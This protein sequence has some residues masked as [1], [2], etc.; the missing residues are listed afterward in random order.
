MTKIDWP[1]GFDRTP[2]TDREP[3]RSFEATIAQ[4]SSA[5]AKE[6]DRMGVNEW[7][8]S[9]ASGG[10][11]TKSNGLPKHSANPDDPAA[12]VYWQKDGEQ[13]A[14]ACDDSPRLRDNM[15]YCYKWINETRMRSNRPV[16]TG[17]SEFATARLPSGNEDAV[18]ADPPA[19]VVLGVDRDASP[20]EVEA[21]FRE[22]AREVHPDAGGSDEAFKRAQ[23]AKEE[24]LPDENECVTDGGTTEYHVVDE[25]DTLEILKRIPNNPGTMPFRH[26][27]TGD[28]PSDHLGIDDCIEA[29]LWSDHGVALCTVDDDVADRT[30]YVNHHGDLQAVSDERAVDSPHEA[31][32]MLDSE[33][34]AEGFDVVAV[35]AEDAPEPARS[36]GKEIVT[37]G[38]ERVSDPGA[39][40][41][42]SSCKCWRSHDDGDCTI[43]GETIAETEA[44][45][46]RVGHCKHDATD[47]YAGRGRG[48]RDML[49]VPKPGKR[50]WLGNPFTL[51]DHSRAES[52]RAFRQAFE[53][54]LQRDDEFRA[55]VADL[56]GKTLGCWCQ[57]VSD[58]EPGCHAEVIAEWA[59]RLANEGDTALDDA[60]QIV[61]D[62]GRP[63]LRRCS[64]CGLIHRPTEACRA[65]NGGG[66]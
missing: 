35:L 65:A 50:G 25:D 28:L 41:Y 21:A 39:R 55:A 26:W 11:H 19:H 61:T 40:V 4:T 10:S 53:D 51:D 38:G 13:F 23:R 17:E 63:S 2:A 18:A 9:T 47:V 62:G 33:L 49:S 15:R 44:E 58:S 27:V 5:L 22:T 7:R 8:V 6:M 59:D 16:E 32:V 64:D 20:A 43:C 66:D 42:C 57:H 45:E 54:K 56:A 12:V 1:A 24:L 14:V 52:I 29:L 34:D 36:V 37:D 3:Y 48:G 46:T 30:Y 60:E 31:A